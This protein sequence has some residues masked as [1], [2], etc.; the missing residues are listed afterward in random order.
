MLILK[1]SFYLLV[2]FCYVWGVLLIDFISI[3]WATT[4]LESDVYSTE[5][6]ILYNIAFLSILLSIVVEVVIVEV[7]V[8]LFFLNNSN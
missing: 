7:V 1:A 4:V 2:L 5:Q 3:L 6:H 8:V